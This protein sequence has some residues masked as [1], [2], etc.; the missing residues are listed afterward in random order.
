MIRL[1]AIILSIAFAG[2]ALVDHGTFDVKSYTAGHQNFHQ[3]QGPSIDVVADFLADPTGALDSSAA[4]DAAIACANASSHPGVLLRIPAG[5]YRVDSAP[6]SVNRHRVH[7]RG[8][9]EYATTICFSPQDPSSLF[10]FSAATLGNSI[11]QS[12][13]SDLAIISSNQ[14]AKVAID[15]EDIREFSLKNIAIQNWTSSGGDSVGLR[16]RGREALIVDRLSVRADNCI[17]IKSDPAISWISADHFHFSNLYLIGIVANPLISVDNDC[18]VY[19]WII[20]GTNIFAGGSHGIY[21]GGPGMAAQVASGISFSNIRREQ[22]NGQNSWLMYL[23]PS[24]GCRD[25]TIRNV[26]G[27][28]P[29]NGYYLRSNRVLMEQIFYEC[30]VPGKIAIDAS[31]VSR[32]LTVRSSFWQVGPSAITTGLTLISAIYDPIDNTSFVAD[33]IFRGSP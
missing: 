1:L 24:A 19:N 25:F 33:G 2:C 30:N 13:L 20:D 9:G 21:W 5:S 29:A 27:G 22:V 14:V 7:I 6:R 26:Y 16:V 10:S 18:S 17:Q 15:L 3:L 11:C 12:S 23:N 32:L 8:D 31:G 4:L 28:W